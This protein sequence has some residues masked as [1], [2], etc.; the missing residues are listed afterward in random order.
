MTLMG[1]SLPTFILLNVVL[2]KNAKK[3]KADA[4]NGE[5][6]EF[7]QKLSQERAKEKDIADAQ[8]RFLTTSQVS[9]T[10]S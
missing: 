2:H 4:I 8:E 9:L 7:V 10:F 3:K 6:T 5:G 1:L